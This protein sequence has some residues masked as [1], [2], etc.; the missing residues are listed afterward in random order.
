[1]V[2]GRT[3][4]GAW[5]ARVPRVRPDSPRSP[6]ARRRRLVFKCIDNPP[7]RRRHLLSHALLPCLALP[8]RFALPLA[9]SHSVKPKACACPPSPSPGRSPQIP[10][11]PNWRNLR[12]PG[13]PPAPGRCSVRP[14]SKVRRS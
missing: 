3:R 6:Q 1:M 11:A 10:S 12:V 7:P 8:P 5:D 13:A 9:R 4:Q 14:Q 2:A